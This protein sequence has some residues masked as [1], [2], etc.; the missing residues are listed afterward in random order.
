MDDVEVVREK[1]NRQGNWGVKRRIE[2][3]AIEPRARS[4]GA[5]SLPR[6]RGKRCGKRG[7]NRPAKTSVTQENQEEQRHSMTA[8]RD[9]ITGSGDGKED[10]AGQT[11]WNVQIGVS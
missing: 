10:E 3:A 5:L 7:M 6:V 4:L 2:E 8:Q 1:Q 11:A 9:T